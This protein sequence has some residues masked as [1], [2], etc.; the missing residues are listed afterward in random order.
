M[1]ADALPEPRRAPLPGTVPVRRVY[2]DALNRAM[3][4][5]V[6]VS[7]GDRADVGDHVVVP[8]PVTVPLVGGVLEVDLRPGAYKLTAKLRTVDGDKTND[9]AEIDVERP[10]R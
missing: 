5:E 8:A 4:G 6:V 10:A 9:V 7:G 2:V 1:P 3:S